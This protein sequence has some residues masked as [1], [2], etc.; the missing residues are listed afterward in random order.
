MPAIDDEGR[1]ISPFYRS[2]DIASVSETARVEVRGYE[3]PNGGRP[4]SAG[5]LV[6]QPSGS[7]AKRIIIVLMTPQW[8]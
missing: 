8:G 6:S 7:S 3:A 2:D 1:D 5:F 4:C